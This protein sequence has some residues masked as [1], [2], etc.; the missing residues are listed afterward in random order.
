MRRTHPPNRGA[1]LPLPV[2]TMLTPTER[3]R[4]DAAGDGAYRALHRDS[5]RR[6]RSRSQIESRER[7]LVSVAR[8]DRHEPGER[9]RARPRVSARADGRAPHRAR[10]IDAARD[11]VARLDGRAAARR[12]PRKPRV[13]ASFGATCS[14]RAAKTMQREALSQLAI[15]LSGVPRDCWRF[16]E[17]LFVAP[18]TRLHRAAARR[19]ASDVLPS[20]LMSRFFR[21]E[22]PAPKQYLATARLVRAARLF[23][24]PGFS[25]ANVANHLDYSSPQSFGRHV[26]TLMQMTAGQFREQLRRRGNARS[27]FASRSS[28]RTSIDCANC[29]RSVRR[30]ARSTRERSC[31]DGATRDARYRAIR[32]TISAAR[33]SDTTSSP[34]LRA[35]RRRPPRGRRAPTRRRRCRLRRARPRSPGAPSRPS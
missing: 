9:R 7:G 14:P 33:V 4:V 35:P 10:S 32:A 16:F 12:R 21:A 34:P 18:P 19:I 2:A 29:G 13:G 1:P 20:T 22:L 15:D 26:R 17:A 6:G 5:R 27:T 30:G 31:S 23:E 24:N 28:S 3:L 25:V 8:C 11:A